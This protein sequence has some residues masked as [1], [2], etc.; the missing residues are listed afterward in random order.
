MSDGILLVGHGTVDDLE[1]LPDFVARIRRGHPAPPE[2]LAELRRRYETI[3][4]SP[5]NA[6]NRRL[7]ARVAER[8]G[9]PARVANRLAKPFVKD[10]LAE[11]AAAGVTR[12]AEVPL[13]QYS[14]HVYADATR[15]AAAAF[16]SEGGA[17]LDVAAAGCWADEEELLAEYVSGIESAVASVPDRKRTTVVL[18]AHSLPVAAIRAG[19]P[20]ERDVRATADAITVR[21]ASRAGEPPPRTVVT[22]QSQGMSTGPGGKPDGTSPASPERGPHQI[23]WLGP[24]LAATI[25]AC[26]ARGDA[27]VVFAP[28]GFLADHVEV[29]Y[30]LDVEAKQ[31]VEKAGMRY[32]RTRLPNDG[33]AI[34][35]AITHVAQRLLGRA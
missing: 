22:F 33:D 34:V 3:G 32:H 2:L 11:M 4:G 10:V 31:W 26:R 5:L 8:A 17:R 13:A 1:D 30:D 18:S 16:A 35:R 19:D 28:I 7:A 6:I 15:E 29:L 27:D 14:A 9:L 21:L 25:E 23:E 24:D 12:V 20:Y